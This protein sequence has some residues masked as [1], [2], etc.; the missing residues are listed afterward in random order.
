MEAVFF[1]SD[2]D[3][4][5]QLVQTS[6]SQVIAQNTGEARIRGA[7][8]SL[9]L[10]AW[11]WMRGSVNYTFQDSE[12]RSDTFRRG[13][14]LPGR[15]RHVVSA[16]ASAAR[17]WGRPYYEFDYVGPNYHD[18]AAAALAGSGLPRDLIRIPG[19][20][21][22]SLGYAQSAGNLEYTIEVTNLFDV[23]TVDIVRYPLPGRVVQASLRVA[24]P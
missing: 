19:R 9:G 10:G 12:D 2:A 5:I 24:L 13:D 23:K 6:Q 1:A 14:D 4:L 22:H 18:A 20:Y 11:G 16:R 17:A 15:P 3:N 7:E 8:L 21:I